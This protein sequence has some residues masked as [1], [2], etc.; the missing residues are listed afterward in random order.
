MLMDIRAVISLVAVAL[1]A[2]AEVARGRLVQNAQG[3]SVEPLNGAKSK[4][5]LLG[6][7]Y[8]CDAS[9][10][11]PS[12]SRGCAVWSESMRKTISQTKIEG[13]T[14]L[15]ESSGTV[16]EITGRDEYS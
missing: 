15:C 5:I 2:C 13:T 4:S 16:T 3:L 11:V 6:V 7:S 14:P 1:A 8:V 10:N 12:A 9:V